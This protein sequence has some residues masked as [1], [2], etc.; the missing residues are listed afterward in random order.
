MVHLALAFLSYFKLTPLRPLTL[1]I[2]FSS[3]WFW[4]GVDD[5]V[6]FPA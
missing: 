3:R 4:N 2:F 5:G 6:I 1:A